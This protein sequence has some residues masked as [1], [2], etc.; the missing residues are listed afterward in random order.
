MLNAF[1][2]FE[3]WNQV[4]AL[5]AKKGALAVSSIFKVK[6]IKQI[7]DAE[8][9]LR[10]LEAAAAAKKLAEQKAKVQALRETMKKDFLKV[11]EEKKIS[12]GLIKD[13]EKK[14]KREARA[15]LKKNFLKVKNERNVDNAFSDNLA[16]AKEAAAKI[17]AKRLALEAALAEEQR[18]LREAEEARRVAEKKAGKYSKR[19]CEQM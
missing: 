3:F 2:I 7:N 18:K 4:K 12:N 11:R 16:R 5:T 13:L 14:H 6:K 17:E 19:R 9:K 1:A 10:E 8:R 15:M